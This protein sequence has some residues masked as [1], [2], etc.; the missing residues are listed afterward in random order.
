MN[1]LNPFEHELQRFQPIRERYRKALVREVKWPRLIL[2]FIGAVSLM[3]WL[4]LRATRGP[5][6]FHGIPV[7]RLLLAAYGL[8]YAVIQL[9]GLGLRRRRKQALRGLY[10]A[11]SE[12]ELETLARFVR[13]LHLNG[14]G[15]LPSA[16]YPFEYQVIWRAAARSLLSEE[17]WRVKSA[18]QYVL[19]YPSDGWPTL[20]GHVQHWVLAAAHEL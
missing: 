9:Y 5:M 12:V 19:G 2:F 1:S 15:I 20:A 6:F 11:I 16:P 7:Y 8:F 14:K 4:V 10:R 13:D 18:L 3:A 17:S